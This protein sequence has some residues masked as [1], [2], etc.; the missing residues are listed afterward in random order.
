M[1]T[2]QIDMGGL[3]KY[4]LALCLVFLISLS[5]GL[6][7]QLGLGEGRIKGIVS[8]E[9]GLPV[10]GAEIE[11]LNTIYGIKYT[12]V[13]DAKG[14]WGISG[15]ASAWYKI[16]VK[17]TGYREASIEFQLSLVARRVQVLDVTLKSADST[18]EQGI[19][20]AKGSASEGLL[21]NGNNLFNQQKYQEALAKFEEFKKDNPQTYQVD[22]NI[23]NCLLEMKEYDRAIEA[24]GAF[25]DRIKSLKGTLSGDENVAKVLAT[26][27]RAYLDKGD[28]EKAKEYF[29]LA[30]DLFPSDAVLAYNLG[31]IYFNQGQPD[32]SIEYLLVAIKINEKW[33]SPYIKLGYAYL[34]KGQYREALESMK[35]F[36]ELAPDDPQAAVVKNLLPKLEELAKSEKKKEEP[37][38]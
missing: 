38:D 21:Q 10:A 6:Y 11:I 9:A 7:A 26:M 20:A 32:K 2:H 31:D 23:G 17:K 8:D 3:V 18:S 36:L 35:K 33:D 1:Q 34:N 16:S 29:K 12:S 13:S 14:R 30:I 28:I 24:Y 25:I 4:I 37:G 5:A 27:G 22:I 19:P 15:V